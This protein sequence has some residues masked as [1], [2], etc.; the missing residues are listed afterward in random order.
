MSVIQYWRERLAARNPLGAP[1]WKSG[2][3]FR[4]HVERAR[5]ADTWP[6]AVCRDILYKDYLWWFDNN[7]LKAY[8]G[9]AFFDADNMPKPEEQLGF[10]CAMSPMLYLVGK[11]VQVRNYQVPIQVQHEG[12]WTQ[13][14]KWRY[15]VRL[16]DWETHVAAFELH[17][18]LP[19]AGNVAFFEAEKAKRL[20]SDVNN[21]RLKIAGIA[22]AA[23]GG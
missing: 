22:R 6:R 1:I 8:R 15:F 18:G 14:R 23:E 16:C 9:V 19:V 10:F 12:R 7:F 5:R 13:V 3:D 21:F 17:T 11:D 4:P 20:S 2:V